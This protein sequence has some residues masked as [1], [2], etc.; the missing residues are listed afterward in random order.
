M[1][2]AAITLVYLFASVYADN[3]IKPCEGNIGVTFVA[4]PTDCSKYYWCLGNDRSH[5]LSCG[6]LTVW[7]DV[8]RNC[9]HKFS[10]DDT[11]TPASER[12]KMRMSVAQLIKNAMT[13]IVAGSQ[14]SMHKETVMHMRPRQPLKTW[15]VDRVNNNLQSPTDIWDRSQVTTTTDHLR[16]QQPYCPPGSREKFAHPTECAR[17]YDC[18]APATGDVW[19]RHLR[20]CRH[21]FVFDDYSKECVHYKRNVCGTRRIPLDPCDYLSNQCRTAHCVPC[22]IRFATCSGMPDGLNPWRGR[23]NSPFF[24]SCKDQRVEIHGRCLWPQGPPLVFDPTERKCIPA[25]V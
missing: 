5:R 11:C 12:P 20:E 9:V 17:F 15:A 8:Q 23:A 1:E 24:V 4:D 14:N 7:S 6:Q 22:R 25:Q 21:P 16:I 10:E 19:G 18:A 3:H 13:E 2:I